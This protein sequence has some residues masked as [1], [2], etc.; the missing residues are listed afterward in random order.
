MQALRRVAGGVLTLVAASAVLAAAAP[1]LVALPPARASLVSWLT[2]NPPD[3]LTELLWLGV[4]AA[5]LR[6]WLGC[7]L[8]VA[9]RLPGALGQACRWAAI[10]ISPAYLVRLLGMAAGSGLGLVLATPAA[11]AGG[12]ATSAVTPPTYAVA[13]PA[14]PGNL[15]W[16]AP[17]MTHPAAGP[18]REPHPASPA[19]SRWCPLGP[20]GALGSADRPVG[21]TQRWPSFDW[22]A[23]NAAQFEL[24]G[25]RKIV[26]VASGDTLWQIAATHL[27]SGSSPAQ[28][29]LAWP[30]WWAA[31]RVVVGPDP[32]LIRPGERLR[33]PPGSTD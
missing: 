2:D 16:P 30:S 13:P 17:M 18:P 11:F 5:T 21:P 28:V 15:S 9:A 7:G 12:P 33:A 20:A 14:T 27:P 10:Q 6:I 24:A 1:G 26:V 8:L 4:A 22:P 23:G 3:R 25:A 29:A 32:N 19:S 31:N